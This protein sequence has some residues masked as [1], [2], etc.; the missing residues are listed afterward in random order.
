MN[1]SS[2]ETLRKLAQYQGDTTKVSLD[3]QAEILDALKTIQENTKKQEAKDISD[4]LAKLTSV[5]GPQGEKGEKGDTGERGDR[6]IAGRDGK[7]G[8]KGEKGDAGVSPSIEDIKAAVVAILPSQEASKA[9]EET[10]EKLRDKLEGLLDDE[11]LDISAIKGLDLEK[12]QKETIE[13]TLGFVP[14]RSGGGVTQ[15]KSSNSSVT[16]VSSMAKGKGVVDIKAVP[17]AIGSTITGGT[18]KSV[19]FVSPTGVIAEDN[20][21]FNYD[22]TTKTLSSRAFSIPTTTSTVGQILQ[23]GVSLLHTYGTNN[24]FLGQGSGNFTVTGDRNVSLGGG[25]LTFL[26]NGTTNI[27]LGYQSLYSMISGSSNMSIGTQALYLNQ[28][29]S[30]NTAV[31]HAALFLAQGSNCVGIGTTALQNTQGGGNVGIGVL[32]GFSHS[33]G[34]S[35]M[36]LGGFNYGVANG[37]YN[38]FIGNNIPT[39]AD[40][41]NNIVLADG[42]GNIRLRVDASAN[43]GVNMTS[44]GGGSKVI[45][46]ANATAPSSN[47]SGGGILYVE[48]GALKYRGSSGTVTT[49]A[50]A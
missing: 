39:Q 33:S 22:Q 50:V 36:F 19:L 13:K 14:S 46:I 44:F 35:N 10:P 25:S 18:N 6:G 15:I 21:N 27:A 4:V 47:P 3:N 40:C 31:G 8:D 38:T 32:A 7:D 29:G 26:T 48:S 42:Q 37:S 5:T 9:E 12:L 28:Y 34:D 16:V 43:F 20:S 17:L 2:R 45:G 30:N 24:L 11:R 49:I 23:N 1:N 41:S